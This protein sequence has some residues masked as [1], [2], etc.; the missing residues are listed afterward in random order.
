MFQFEM[1][2]FKWNSH[3]AAESNFGMRSKTFDF[4]Y[5]ETEWSDVPDN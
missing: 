3:Q 1:K 5:P 4:F 2:S